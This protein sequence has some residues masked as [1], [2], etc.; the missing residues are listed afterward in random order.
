MVWLTHVHFRRWHLWYTPM[1]A[2]NVR[3]SGR[4]GSHRGPAKPTR[5]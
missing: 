2:E 5:M 3:W 4:T 1:G